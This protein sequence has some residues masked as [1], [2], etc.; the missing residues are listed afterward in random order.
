M[1]TAAVR[2]NWIGQV[3]DGRFTLLQWLGSSASNDVFLTE[4]QGPGSQKAAIK[5]VHADVDGSNTYLSRWQVATTLSHPHL[6]RLLHVGRCQINTAELLYVVMEYAEEDLSQIL[7][8]RPLTPDE[9]REMLCPLLDALSY[10]HEKGFVHGHLKPS[11]IMVVND[12]LKL[13]SDSL[14]RPGELD[15]IIL[16]SNLYVPAEAEISPAADVWSLGVTLVEAL[17]QRPPTWDRATHGDPV[18]PKSFPQP[19]A[20]IAQEC[21]RSDPVRRCTVAEIRAR[22]QPTRSHQRPASKNGREAPAK[23]RATKLIGAALVLLAIIAVL[24]FVFH[25][26]R[27]SLPAQE[28]QPPSAVSTLPFQSQTSKGTAIKGAVTERVLPDVPR[29]A[30]RTIQGKVTVRIRVTVDP[31]GEV[32]SV[33]VDSVGPSKYFANLALQAARRWKFKPAQVDGQAV[34]SVWVLRFQ[35]GQAAT[36]VTPIE[37]SP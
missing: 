5:L 9:A 10:L 30:S 29:A 32:S 22:L 4:L 33:K 15:K 35:F 25:Q 27:P 24:K 34:P 2:A 23:L 37:A 17:T 31:R 1:N 13:S 21:L 26:A 8:Q 18:V 16:A 6:V 11:N 19:F 3:I 14:S 20:D 28:Q 12:E 7:P 36:E